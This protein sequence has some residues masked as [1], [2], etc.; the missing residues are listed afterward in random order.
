MSEVD[1][2]GAVK[3]RG[4]LPDRPWRSLDGFFG[5]SERGTRVG[6]ELIAGLTTFGSM[7]Y[8]LAVNPTIL[9]V[10]GMDHTQLVIVTALASMFGTLIMALWANLPIALAPGM[11]NN[12]IF[13]QVVV[14][15]LGLSFQIALAMVFVNSLLFMA[16]AMTGWRE[17]IIKGFPDP[18]RIGI[19]CG[20]GL[21][22]AWVGLKNSGLLVVSSASVGFAALNSAAAV[23]AYLGLLVTALLVA[24]RV[25]AAL[26]LSILA[27]SVIGLLVPGGA[28][29][30]ITVV[31]NRL[32]A[33]PVTPSQTFMALD[34]AGLFTHFTTVL[35]VILYLCISDFFGVTATLVGVLRRAGMTASDGRI[36]NGFQAFAADGIASSVGALLGTSS[37]GV[38]VESATGVEA[39][40]RTGLTA[41]TVAALF[42]ASLFLWPLLVCIPAQATAPALLIVGV[43]MMEGVRDIDLSKAENVFPALL[44]IILTACTTDLLMSL[45]TGC[46]LYTLIVAAKRQWQLLTPILIGLDIVF[47]V[48][49]GLA[50]A[51]Q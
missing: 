16:L 51:V 21:F 40:G 46:F 19:Q 28:G 41:V 31:P 39:G 34:L 35:P 22:I 44:I 24:L 30:A 6:R 50:P 49:I 1:V 5:L 38:Y 13:A 23:L 25:P 45:A 47:I 36:P 42:G 15:R 27:I 14:L 32:F 18:M 17:R 43:L 26:L 29:A 10:T 12:V 20:L 2:I 48:Y 37:V 9:G 3:T 4:S 11:G 33:W 7:S 8:I